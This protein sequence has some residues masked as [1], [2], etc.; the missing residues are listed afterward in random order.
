MSII[1]LKDDTSGSSKLNTFSTI[2]KLFKIKQNILSV[3]IIDTLGSNSI[4]QLSD[5]EGVVIL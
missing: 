2:I 5:K 1:L 4:S 3:F